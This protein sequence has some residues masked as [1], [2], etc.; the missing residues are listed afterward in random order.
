MSRPKRVKQRPGTERTTTRELT[1][2][3]AVRLLAALPPD[4]TVTVVFHVSSTTGV[5]MRDSEPLTIVEGAQ[6][7][8]VSP[9]TVRDIPGLDWVSYPGRGKRP[10]RRIQRESV[11][12]LLERRRVLA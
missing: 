7:L 9:S 6:M 10:I 5:P 12:R 4:A 8:G 11:E 3:E 2:D 1:R